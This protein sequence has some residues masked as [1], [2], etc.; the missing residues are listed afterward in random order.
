MIGKWWSNWR[1][2]RAMRML[3]DNAAFFG[4]DLNNLSDEEIEKSVVAATKALPTLGLSMEEAD[5]AFRRFGRA[6]DAALQSRKT[7]ARK[8]EEG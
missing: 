8:S 3:R 6:M 2:R 1:K 5:E 4:V 7:P